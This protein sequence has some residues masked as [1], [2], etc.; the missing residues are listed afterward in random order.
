M[1]FQGFRKRRAH[2]QSRIKGRIRILKYDLY[3][4][5]ES[6]QLPLRHGEQ[7]KPSVF[8]GSRNRLIQPE[9][10]SAQSGFSASGFTYQAQVLNL[11]NDLKQEFGFTAV[12]ISHDLSVIRYL[13][14]RVMV[15]EKGHIVE[16]G[17]AE[18]VYRNPKMEYTKTLIEA[19]P[20]GRS[21]TVD[22]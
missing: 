1:D 21:L 17:D 19:I 15:M 12:F 5:A 11:I 18:S 8:D 2:F 7:V 10:G 22:R 9:Q 20:G 16:T 14:D 4:F 13:C 6:P 3:V